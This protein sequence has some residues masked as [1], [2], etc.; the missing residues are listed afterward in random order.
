MR[1]ERVTNMKR[2]TLR[3]INWITT[4]VLRA[5]CRGGGKEEEREGEREKERETLHR[6]R[7]HRL[8]EALGLYPLKCKS[9]RRVVQLLQ[10]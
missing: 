5:S 7:D 9:K 10:L 3:V 6:N 1:G 4:S 2:S 8:L